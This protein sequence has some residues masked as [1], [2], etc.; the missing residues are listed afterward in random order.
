M[1]RFIDDGTIADVLYAAAEA[2]FGQALA[3][4]ATGNVKKIALA[5]DFAARG[6]LMTRTREQFLSGDDATKQSIAEWCRK[7]KLVR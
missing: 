5:H 2:A 3:L 6:E 7:N 1:A 4:Q